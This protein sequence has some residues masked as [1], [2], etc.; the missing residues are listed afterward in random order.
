[1]YPSSSDLNQTVCERKLQELSEQL[2][3]LARTP[4]LEGGGDWAV[5]HQG[6]PHLVLLQYREWS[7][8]ALLMALLGNKQVGNYVI[9]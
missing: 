3:V 5:E 7:N 9:C 1:M 8:V 2:D 6:L 4:Q